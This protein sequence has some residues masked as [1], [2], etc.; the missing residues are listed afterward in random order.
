[1]EE[2][3]K[4]FLREESAVETK[5]NLLELSFIKFSYLTEAVIQFSLK[6]LTISVS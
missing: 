4:A 6:L 5:R 2:E 1:M 3:Q